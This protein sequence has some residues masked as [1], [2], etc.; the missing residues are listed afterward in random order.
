MSFSGRVDSFNEH[1]KQGLQAVPVN[2]LLLET[3]LTPNGAVQ[4]ST[5]HWRGSHTR[6]SGETGASVS[7]ARDGECQLSR[8]VSPVGPYKWGGGK[9]E[10]AKSSSNLT[11][12]EGGRLWPSGDDQRKT[13]VV[14]RR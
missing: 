14:V 8:P 11:E 3:D 7:G 6:V 13:H 1:Q 12:A 10:Y 5:S 4:H 9:V 2:R